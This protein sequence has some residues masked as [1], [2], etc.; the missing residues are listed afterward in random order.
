MSSSV[1]WTSIWVQL[2]RSFILRVPLGNE[3]YERYVDRGMDSE[4]ASPCTAFQ[5]WSAEITALINM[6]DIR[7]RARGGRTHHGYASSPSPR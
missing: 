6:Y 5:T 2:S 1:F 3:I 7:D 4:T